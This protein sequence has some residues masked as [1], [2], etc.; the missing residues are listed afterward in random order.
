[1]S[2]YYRSSFGGIGPGGWSPAVRTLII[3]CSVVFVLQTF[4]SLAGGQST[5]V[6]KFGLNPYLVTHSFYL[7]QLVTYIFLH[8]GI[9]HILF[10]MLGLWMFGTDLERLWGT[11][12]FTKAFFLCGI[13]GAVFKVLLNPSASQIT[14]GASG[15]ILGLLVAYG[16]LFPERIIILF[17]FPIKVKWFVIGYAV[18]TVLSSISGGGMT[19][20]QVHLGGMLC[21]LFYM[22]G[23]RVFSDIRWQY[24]KWR[25]ARLRRKFEVYYNER[26][27]DDRDNG[28]QKWRRWKN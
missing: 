2:R 11:R 24:D 23:G 4:D 14:L 9:M 1:V 18:L 8:G 5:I 21:G 3:V 22:K 25:R 16:F 7:W 28:E 12:A 20:Y 17:I 19:D 10:N 15:A 26:H 27:R 13:G 6:S